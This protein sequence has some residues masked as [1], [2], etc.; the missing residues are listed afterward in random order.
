MLD[1]HTGSSKAN[2]RFSLDLSLLREPWF[3]E[4]LVPRSEAPSVEQPM[5]VP[6]VFSLLRDGQIFA[7]PL[8]S[9]LQL[10]AYM[11]TE[12]AEIKKKTPNCRVD[13]KI[14]PLIG[15]KYRR[16]PRGTTFPLNNIEESPIIYYLLQ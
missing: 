10:C 5:V 3:Q 2:L 8:M 7:L 14:S 9:T 11:R 13:I 15:K 4:P 16:G 12:H 6:R 1:C